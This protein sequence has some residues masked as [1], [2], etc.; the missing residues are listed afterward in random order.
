[1]N[2]WL[3]L[4]LPHNLFIMDLLN[5]SVNIC[6]FFIEDEGD[7]KYVCKSSIDIIQ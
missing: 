6:I 5:M 2:D 7:I 1:M 3:F 4:L